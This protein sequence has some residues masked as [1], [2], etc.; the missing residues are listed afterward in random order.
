MKACSLRSL[1]L[2]A[3]ALAAMPSLAAWEP[4]TGGLAPIPA[5]TARVTDATGTL[6]PDERSEIEGRIGTFEQ[7]T[8]GQL[9]VLMVPSTQPEPIESYSIRVAEA[10]KIGRKGQDN[11][12]LFLIAKNDRKMRF[13]V[14]YGYEGVLPD[15]LARGVIGD[16]VAPLFGQ[17][18]F[19]AGIDAGIDRVTDILTKSGE[20]SAPPPLTQRGKRGKASNFDPGLIFILLFVVI[21]VFGGIL[22]AI[23]GKLFGSTIGG[24]I[25]GAVAWFLVGSLALA[26]I[27]G[28]VSLLVMLFFGG[29]GGLTRGGRGGIFPGGFGG[30]G[31]GFGGGGFG[32]SG[33]GGFSGGGGSFGGGG[34]SGGW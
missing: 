8:G 21:P 19:A 1:A 5:L 3:F 28:V 27:A 17:N 20:V 29:G 18:K 30:G 24:G 32:G 11:G 12:I 31:G 34:A 2:A 23:F 26:G 4:A 16:T 6:T 33:G 15:A 14:G 9:V 22:K 7:K 13:E 10:W 25:V